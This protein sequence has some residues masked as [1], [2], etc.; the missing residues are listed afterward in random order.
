MVCEDEDP[1]ASVKHVVERCLVEVKDFLLI[2]SKVSR[3][4]VQEK[5]Q[6]VFGLYDLNGDGLITKKEMLEV[7]NSIYEMVGRSTKPQVEE[8]SAKEHVEKIFHLIDTNK[9]GVV[10]IDELVEWCSRD[11]QILQS[12]ET[13]DT[14]L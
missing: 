4:S 8:N 3:G 11:E 14:V 10:T 5:L 12:L 9:D 2:L 13:L 1:H 7:V 6:W